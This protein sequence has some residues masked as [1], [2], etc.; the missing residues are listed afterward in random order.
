[1]LDRDTYLSQ[2]AV[3]RA[4]A[5]VVIRDAEGRVLVVEPTYKPRWELPGGAVD[6]DESP[7]LAAVREV[8][9]ELGLDLAV[10]RLLVTDHARPTERTPVAMLH[11][12]F[13]GPTLT[14]AESAGI[15]LPP[16]EL[17]DVRFVDVRDA[18]EMVG[19]RIG[20]RLRHALSAAD[21]GTAYYLE[22]GQVPDPTVRH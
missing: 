11:F 12:L 18:Q 2:L 6:P 16:T 1:M 4:S 14:A 21:T 22:N 17:S 19:S 15:R 5:A 9:E 8:R 13:A 20:P 10:G 3:F 7:Y